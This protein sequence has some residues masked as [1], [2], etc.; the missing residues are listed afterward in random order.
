[1]VVIGAQM[2]AADLPATF[3]GR[4]LYVSAVLKLVVS[5]VLAGV[6]LLPFHLDPMSYTALVVLAGVPT[7]GV[8]SMFAQQFGRDTD[9]AAQSITLS[10]LLSIIT[11]PVVAVLAQ[12]AAG[13]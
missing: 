1:M 13:L 3:R 5:P 8:T 6:L 9:N 7:A 2:A 11:L 12:R 4:R 10:T